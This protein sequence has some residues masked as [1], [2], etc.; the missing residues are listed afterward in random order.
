MN[1]NSAVINIG[2]HVSLSFLVSSVFMPRSGIAGS[3][4]SSISS[5][6]RNLHTVLHISCTSLHSHQQLENVS[7]SPHPLPDLLFLDS[8]MMAIL[9]SVRCYLI[10]VLIYISLIMRN[11]Q[12]LFM[13]LLAICKSSLEKCLLRSF[14]YF[15]IGL[16]VF[17]VLSCISCLYILEINPLSVVSF[18]IIF[19]HSEGCLFTL[20][21]VSFAVPKLFSL[22]SPTCLLLFLF[23]LL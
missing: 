3:Y 4:V 1:I 5:F 14:S 23:P 21:I 13:C 12:P 6:L 15:L 20:L 17:L 19:S 2:V 16:F 22:I 8:L 11:V 7:F 10:V 9:T 18:A